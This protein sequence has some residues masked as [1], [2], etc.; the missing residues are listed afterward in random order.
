VARGVG[1]IDTLA[2]RDASRGSRGHSEI[3]QQR[4]WREKRRC[5]SATIPQRTTGGEGN[6]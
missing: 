1:G 6:R 5:Q 4:E 3:V 2:G